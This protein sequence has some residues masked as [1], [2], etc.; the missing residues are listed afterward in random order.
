MYRRRAEYQQAEGIRYFR[1]GN[2]V[3][4]G[5]DGASPK[6]G[7]AAHRGVKSEQNATCNDDLIAA[8]LNDAK[9]CERRHGTA[10][11]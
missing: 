6:P 10:F 8:V 11:E 9:F 2:A 5:D 3:R 7:A 1:D 4:G